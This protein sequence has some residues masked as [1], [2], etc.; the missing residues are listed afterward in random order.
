MKIS[1]RG[2]EDLNCGILCFGMQSF[3]STAVLIFSRH[4][5][6]RTVA[7]FW[8]PAKLYIKKKKANTAPRLQFVNRN[9]RSVELVIKFT[10][11][12]FAGRFC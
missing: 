12:H 11:F 9:I 7:Q 10:S 3:V 6:V 8:C 2:S 1:L 5:K 4:V